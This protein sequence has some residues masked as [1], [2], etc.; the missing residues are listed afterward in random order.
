MSSPTQITVTPVSGSR[1]LSLFIKLPRLLYDGLPS[2][3]PPLDMEQRDIFSPTHA[4]FFEH[5]FAC[6]FLAW[7]NGKP[8]GRISAQIDAL[9]LKQPGPRT[10]FFGALDTLEPECVAPLLEAATQWLKLRKVERIRGPW[11]L[12]SNGESGIMVE[13]QD[14]PPMIGI[15]WHPKILGPAVEAAGFK[16]AV[17]LLSYRMETSPSAERANQIPANI[18]QRLGAITMRGLRKD[19]VNEDAEILREI[20]NDAWSDTWGNIPLTQ[21]EVKSLL[22]ALKPILRPE[23]YVLAEVA[24][25][26]AAIALVIPNMFD[27]SGDLGGAPSPLGWLKLASRVVSHDFRSARVVLLGVRKKYLGTALRAMLPALII[28]ELMKRGHVLPYR[29]IELGWVLETHEGLRKLIERISPT[30]YKRHRMYE[31]LLTD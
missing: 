31:K 19:K 9:A 13:G 6:Y 15:P 17:D 26:P 7:R 3:V 23:Q 18:R 8:I 14:E 22:K 4:P 21:D 1:Q 12:N 30:P 11:T 25:E 29:S 10:G 27:I 20:Y 2:Y 28:D 24:G 16:R 5:G